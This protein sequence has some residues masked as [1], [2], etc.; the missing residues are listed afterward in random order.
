MAIK[1][2]CPSCDRIYN[3]G[4]DLEGEKFRCKNCDRRFM[5]KRRADRFADEDDEEERPKRRRR[6]KKKETPAW[7]W[8]ASIGGGVAV[9]ALIVVVIVAAWPDDS[10]GPGGRRPPGAPMPVGQQAPVQDNRP[11]GPHAGIMQE[12]FGCVSASNN[13]MAQVR[14]PAAVD[15]T[16][17]QLLQQATRIDQLTQKL[18]AAGRPGPADVAQLRQIDQQNVGVAK[19]FEAEAIRMRQQLQTMKLTPATANNIEHACTTFANSMRNFWN[20]AQTF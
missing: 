1:T 18:Q 20:I 12:F 13:A 5:V 10:R 8:F 4:D 3:L 9:V 6:K 16:A 11:P 17:T 2:A 15:N 7:V 14:T 19:R